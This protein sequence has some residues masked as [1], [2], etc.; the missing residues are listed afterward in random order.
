MLLHRHR[1]RRRYHHHLLQHSRRYCQ[2]RSRGNDCHP[3]RNGWSRDE[4]RLVKPR[5]L[6]QPE[7][8]DTGVQVSGGGGDGRGGA[9]GGQ[10]YRMACSVFVPCVARCKLLP[11]GFRLAFKCLNRRER[12]QKVKRLCT[13]SARHHASTLLLRVVGRWGLAATAWWA[14]PAHSA[15]FVGRCAGC[16]EQGYP[17][18]SGLEARSG[19]TT[20]AR[21]FPL[22]PGAL[23]VASSFLQPAGSAEPF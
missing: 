15:W 2:H 18:R 7:G 11:L 20:C 14:M 8:H 19:S 4:A 17:H 3:R 13:F 10:T 9:G 22:A 16:N 12:S 23:D 1:H 21:Q 5:G 6:V